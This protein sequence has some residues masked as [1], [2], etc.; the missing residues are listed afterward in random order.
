METNCDKALKKAEK[1]D[2]KKWQQS[3]ATLSDA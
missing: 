3:Q 1:E 2:R